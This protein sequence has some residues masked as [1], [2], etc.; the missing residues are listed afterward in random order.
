MNEETVLIPTMTFQFTDNCG[1]VLS[2]GGGGMTLE[3]LH[4]EAVVLAADGLNVNFKIEGSYKV[5]FW[6]MVG[7][8]PR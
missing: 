8:S 7:H 6:E 3:D 2:S 1:N 5:R 4:K